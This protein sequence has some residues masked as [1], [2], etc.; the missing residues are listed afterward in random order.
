[1]FR[2]DKDTPGLL[3]ENL[4]LVV[5]KEQKEKDTFF[6]ELVTLS[7]VSCSY[8]FLKC[9]QYTQYSVLNLANYY[10][11]IKLYLTGILYFFIIGCLEYFFKQLKD[12]SLFAFFLWQV[13]TDRNSIKLFSLLAY[14]FSRKI[15][16]PCCH[17]HP[18]Y[19]NL[20]SYSYPYI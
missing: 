6:V 13:A 15:Q 7:F 4:P 2:N 16:V 14:N 3:Q 18:S 11:L 17:C 5:Q 19:V 8:F 9:Q 10:N 20:S 1:M 12:F